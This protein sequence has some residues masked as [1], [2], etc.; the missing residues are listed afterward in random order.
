MYAKT[1]Y[2]PGNIAALQSGIGLTYGPTIG[3]NDPGSPQS[4]GGSH[5]AYTIPGLSG[6]RCVG[7]VRG[8]APVPMKGLLGLALGECDENCRKWAWYG[9]GGVAILFIFS[10]LHDKYQYPSALH[11]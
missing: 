11:Y 2:G 7:K 9:V 3:S 10:W 4:A 5:G 6:C 8:H 1:S